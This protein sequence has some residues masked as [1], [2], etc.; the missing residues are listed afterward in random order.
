MPAPKTSRPVIRQVAVLPYRIG[1]SGE[2]SILLIT[3][4]RTGRWVIPKGNRIS[5][6][7]SH[8]AAAQ[9]AFEEAGVSGTTSPKLLGV[10]RYDKTQKDGSARPATVKV[11]AFAFDAQSD[12]WP[13]QAQRDTRWFGLDE[14]VDAVDE[15]ELKTI[16]SMFVA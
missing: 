10:Y 5:G 13:E 3:S 1:E 12:V 6:L 2:I 8:K 14:A 15:P 7:S 16:I 11:Y 9:E 4:R